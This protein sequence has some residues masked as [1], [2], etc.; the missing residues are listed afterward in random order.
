VKAATTLPVLVG[1]GVRADNVAEIMAAADGV[2]VG[3]SLK[4]GGVWWEPVE[5][6]RVSAFM[7]SFREAV[8]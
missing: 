2:I 1:S 4:H 3:S 5:R 8:G 6:Q 7:R